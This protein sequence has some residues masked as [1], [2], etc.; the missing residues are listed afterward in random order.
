MKRRGHFAV[1]GRLI[2]RLWRILAASLAMAAVLW[3]AERP[4]APMLAVHGLRVVGLALLVTVGILSFSLAALVTG[5][6]RLG[7]MKAML[8]RRSA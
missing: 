3:V 2:G 4:L 1:D 7:E 5:A 6:A 8:R